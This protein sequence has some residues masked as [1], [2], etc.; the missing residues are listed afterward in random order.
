VSLPYPIDGRPY[1][2]NLAERQA[3]RDRIRV[4]MLAQAELQIAKAAR[5]PRCSG[6]ANWGQTEHSNDFGGCRNDGSTC[7]CECH[8]ARPVGPEETS[9]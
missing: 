9:P 5:S 3:E 8:D 2:R 4:Y 7:L 6:D 1:S